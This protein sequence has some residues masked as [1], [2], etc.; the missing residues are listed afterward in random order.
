M[1]NT[2]IYV[3]VHLYIP[4]GSMSFSSIFTLLFTFVVKKALF[5]INE[6][7]TCCLVLSSQRPKI[8]SK[9]V[10]N[11]HLYVKVHLYFPRGSMSFTYLF[12]LLFTFV[13][14]KALFCI[15]RSLLVQLLPCV[16]CKVSDN[17]EKY[18]H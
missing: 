11:T 9:T 14:K 10:N 18:K 7:V 2:H 6:F 13:V 5:C 12:T 8:L 17:I 3:K 16:D 4:R 1:N 15:I